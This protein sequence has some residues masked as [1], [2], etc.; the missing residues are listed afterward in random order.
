MFVI[1]CMVVTIFSVRGEELE[2]LSVEINLRYCDTL[3]FSRAK[4]FI[5]CY[6]SFISRSIV[7]KVAGLVCSVHFQKW[8]NFSIERS[9]GKLFLFGKFNIREV[10][11]MKVA[12]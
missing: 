1:F 5:C 7:R 12:R 4:R 2:R 6:A 8:R 11:K 3:L 10:L 9:R